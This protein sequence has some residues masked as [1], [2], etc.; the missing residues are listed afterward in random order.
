MPGRVRQCLGLIGTDLA[1]RGCSGLFLDT[2][3]ARNGSWCVQFMFHGVWPTVSWDEPDIIRV[4]GF[5][6]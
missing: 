4:L 6:R 3:G 2:A 5:A 1:C